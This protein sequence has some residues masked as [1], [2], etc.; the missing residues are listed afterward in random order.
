V[1]FALLGSG[2]IAFERIS[3][4]AGYQAIYVIDATAA[5][6]AHFFDNTLEFG[7]TLSPDGRRLAY[8]TYDNSTLY[9]VFVANLD[10]TG[11][12]HVTRFPLQEGPP[13]WTPD[14]T[15]IIAAGEP[16]S[17][18]IVW[19]AYSQSPV[20]NPT[21]QTQLT[22]FGVSPNGQITCPVIFDNESRIVASAQGALAFP[23]LNSEI[24]VLSPAGTL[25]AAYKPSRSDRTHWPSVFAAKWSPDG[26]RIAF[27]ETISNQD[28]GFLVSSY[29]LKVMNADATNV[30]T[31]SSTPITTTVHPGGGWLGADNFSL[32]WMPDGSRLVF[33]IPETD[34]GGHVW[35]VGAN[36]SG[37][38]QLTSAAQVYDRSLSCSRS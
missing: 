16:G 25:T 27:I 4:G 36:G 21:D 2:K 1:N 3:N 22:N 7:A 15:K 23:C 10:G 6:S 32:C 14:G 35:V 24:D 20:T 11:V 8:T 37:L 5:S 33:N 30:T 13:S 17:S 31:V 26:T 9:D 28:A 38:T 29:A 12:Q 19:H 34:L 18:S